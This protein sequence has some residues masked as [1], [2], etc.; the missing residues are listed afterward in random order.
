MNKGKNRQAKKW[1]LKYRDGY[2]KAGGE[3]WVK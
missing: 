2:Q 1:I 3:A